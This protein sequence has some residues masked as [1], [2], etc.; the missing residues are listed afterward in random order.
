M[1]NKTT[2]A[3]R[4]IAGPNYLSNRMDLMIREC[5]FYLDRMCHTQNSLLRKAYAKMASVYFNRYYYYFKKS[6]A[7]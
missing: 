2:I 4:I 7:Q 5:S 3:R 1:I 6:T